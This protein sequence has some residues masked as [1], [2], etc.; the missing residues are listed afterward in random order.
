MRGCMGSLHGESTQHEPPVGPRLAGSPQ[1]PALV[2]PEGRNDASHGEPVP[3][4]EAAAGEQT[5]PLECPQWMQV[6]FDYVLQV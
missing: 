4:G 3:E 2:C 1:V 6:M 5:E